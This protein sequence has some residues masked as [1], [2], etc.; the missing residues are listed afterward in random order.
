M[1]QI[2]S[3]LQKLET[4]AAVTAAEDPYGIDAKFGL[5]KMN[6]TELKHFWHE[7]T[8]S[9]VNHSDS[10]PEMIA[11]AKAEL[12]AMEAEVRKHVLENREPELAAIIAKNLA[13]YYGGVRPAWWGPDWGALAEA[14][15]LSV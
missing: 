3:R 2:E 8:L 10:T 7:L 15:G 4:V 1:R 11:A 13:E 12:E 14:W 9:I 6:D 5:S